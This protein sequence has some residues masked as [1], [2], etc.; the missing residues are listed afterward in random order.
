MTL[1]SS[2]GASKTPEM[3]QVIERNIQSLLERQQAEE[4][5]RTLGEKVADVI[6]GFAGSMSF[7][8]LHLLVF[9]V[10]IVINLGWLRIAP[11]DP[12][13]AILAVLASIEAIL[14]SVFVLIKQNRMATQAE[15]RAKLDL[16]IS[17]LA[18]HEVTQILK[19]VAGIA[20]RVEVDLG[21]ITELSKLAQDIHPDDLM[22][23]IES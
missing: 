15:A 12:S 19:L 6:T 7:V 11:F 22:Q 1:Q 5:G 4:R 18:E 21:E 20:E 9:A 10:W 3:A 16:Q 23:T 8:Y 14:L 13:L 17:L 2:E